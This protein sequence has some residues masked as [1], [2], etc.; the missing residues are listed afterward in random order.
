M[1]EN[2]FAGADERLKKSSGTLSRGDRDTADAERTNKDGT[3]ITVEER[4]RTFRSEQS[5]EVLPTPPKRDGWHYCWLSTTNGS[6][7]I[8]KR[9]QK[10]YEPVKSS[11]I[12]GFAQYSVSQG[13]FEGCVACNEMVLFKL[14]DELYQAYM[15]HLHYELPNSEESMLK[16]NAAIREQDS[17]GRELGSVEG[18]DNLARKV[19]QPTFA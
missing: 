13:E 11:E 1:T 5:N 17:G 15:N 10:G 16:D 7:P 3:S 19:R 14:P 2:K 9:V 12:Q 6:D 18:F 8:Y 4:M